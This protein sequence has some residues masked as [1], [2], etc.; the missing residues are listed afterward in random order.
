[1]QN[2]EQKGL[3]FHGIKIIEAHLG[4]FRPLEGEFQIELK[5]DAKLVPIEDG[6]REFRI[7]MEVDLMASDFWQIKVKG[8]GDFEIAAEVSLHERNGYVNV[9]A[10]A[11]M[12]PYIRSFI[13]TLT[14]NCGGSIPP[15]IIPPHFFAGE[16]ELLANKVEE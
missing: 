9:N 12:F 14:A 8:I 13:A 1:M 6:S 3:R 10:P 11:I 4:V 5:L 16:L 15:L 7:W 2:D